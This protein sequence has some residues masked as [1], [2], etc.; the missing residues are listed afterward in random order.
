MPD[1]VLLCRLIWAE[2]YEAKDEQIFAGN[3]RYPAALGYG[4]ELLNFADEAGSVYGYVEN[5]NQKL[6]LRRLGARPNADF[7]DGVTI[8]FCAV[9]EATMRLRVVGWYD[10]AI[11]FGSMR[12]AEKGSIRGDW[13]YYFKADADDAHLLPVAARDLEVPR[14]QRITDTGFIGQRNVF[15]PTE[16]PNYER[17]LESFY[18]LKRGIDNR[19]GDEPDNEEYQEGQRAWR[20]ASFLARNPKLVKDAK[21]HHGPT[22]QA[23]GFNFEKVYG[24]LGK[25]YIEVHHKRP[26][27]DGGPRTSTV[28]DVDVICAN[29]H[30]MIHRKG[31]PMTLHQLKKILKEN[32][33]SSAT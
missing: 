6:D 11:A 24:E 26:I 29:C 16:N 2:K 27:A 25:G 23:C 10:N 31:T 30:R 8:I 21:K 15:Y 32:G 9:D 28:Q 7:A 33:S 17:F 20:E 22:C 4:G 13:Q 18:L 19:D 1:K 3:M 5:R 12:K 14:K